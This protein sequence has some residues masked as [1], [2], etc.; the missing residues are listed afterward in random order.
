M[1]DDERLSGRLYAEARAAKWRV[2]RRAFAEALDASAAKAF[3]GQAP[4]PR[5]LE[6]YLSGLHLAD[7]AL[8]CACAAGDDDAWRHFI[9]EY[10]PQLYRAADAIDP[11]GDARDLADAIYADLFGLKGAEGQRRSLFRYFHGR[12]SLATW[13]RAVLSQR[14]VDRLRERRKLEPLPD[15]ESDHVPL[16]PSAPPT[17]GRDRYVSAM[18]SALAFA[19]STLVPKDRLRL[20]CYY[21][22]QMT[23]AQVGR[24]LGE[25]EATVSRQ[26]ART[27]SAVRVA[28]EQQLADVHDLA[29]AQIAECF[30]WIADDVGP[31]DIRE[32]LMVDEAAGRKERAVDRS[33]RGGS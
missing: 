2:D 25:H 24:L 17:P 15:D 29:P 23:L 4:A 3:S 8:A 33:T 13:L 32:L 20:A 19:L 1:P 21:A 5:E 9:S 26:L 27:R 6:R 10:R 14:H 18:R 12:S 31:F 30:R 16:A 28:V 22:R 11:T 7:L